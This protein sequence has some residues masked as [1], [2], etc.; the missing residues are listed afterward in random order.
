MLRKQCG[1]NQ[2]RKPAVRRPTHRRT[3]CRKVVCRKIA[4]RKTV[5]R[6][7]AHR[8]TDIRKSVLRTT[9]II[10]EITVHT[11]D[12]TRLVR[13]SVHMG[14]T[15]ITITTIVTALRQ[16]PLFSRRLPSARLILPRT[17][18]M[19]RMWTTRS[20]WQDRNT[21]MTPWDFPHRI[22]QN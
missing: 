20:V 18:L 14:T 17:R 19:S 5:C 9:G 22:W 13:R 6:R 11:K 1:R 12:L 3:G 4:A 21:E 16:L 10:R 2:S 7:P 8:K 15:I